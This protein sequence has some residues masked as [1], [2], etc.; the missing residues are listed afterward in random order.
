MSSVDMVTNGATVRQLSERA[1]CSVDPMCQI[2]PS[3]INN[4]ACSMRFWGVEEEWRA[5]IK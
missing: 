1:G 3:E 4:V 2:T 5:A